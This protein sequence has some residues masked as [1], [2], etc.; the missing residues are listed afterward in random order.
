MTVSTC[1]S[2]IFTCSLVVLSSLEYEVPEGGNISFDL[3]I[4]KPNAWHLVGS[5]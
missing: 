1:M 5:Q 3:L 2:H 4:D